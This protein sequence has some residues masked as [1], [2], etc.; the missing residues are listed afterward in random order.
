LFGATQPAAQPTSIFGATQPTFGA[1]QPTQPAGMFGS[2]LTGANQIGTTVK[3]EAVAAQGKEM[4]FFLKFIQTLYFF[5]QI[6]CVQKIIH[7]KQ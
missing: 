7:F 4:I 5:V 1:A 2:T 3:F 6:Q